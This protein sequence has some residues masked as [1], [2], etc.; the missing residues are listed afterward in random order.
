MLDSVRRGFP[1]EDNLAGKSHAGVC[2]RELQQSGTTPASPQG[3][4]VRCCRISPQKWRRSRVLTRLTRPAA[5]ASGPRKPLSIWKRWTRTATVLQ[6]WRRNWRLQ[7]VHVSCCV[8][9]WTPRLVWWTVPWELSWRCPGTSWSYTLIT[10]QS[11]TIWRE[12]RAVSWSWKTFTCTGRSSPWSSRMPWPSTSARDSRWTV[13][14]S[15]CPTKCSVQV[16]RM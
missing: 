10:W 4:N 16:W 13:P 5:H 9:I 12:S 1:T 14:S 8:A 11:R 15:T 3:N 7:W 6:A 2:G